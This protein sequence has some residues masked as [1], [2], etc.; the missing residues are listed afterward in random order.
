MRR[1]NLTRVVVVYARSTVLV[2]PCGLDVDGPE[3]LDLCWLSGSISRFPL[4][5]ESWHVTF[6]QL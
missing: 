2:I 6:R 3:G 1:L 5:T 4:T